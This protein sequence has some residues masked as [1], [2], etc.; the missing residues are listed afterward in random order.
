MSRGLPPKF[1]YTDGRDVM[2]L[3]DTFTVEQR[4]HAIRVLAGGARN[5]AELVDWLSM[6]DLDVKEVRPL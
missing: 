5:A 1:T 6:F 3:V 4:R 2:P